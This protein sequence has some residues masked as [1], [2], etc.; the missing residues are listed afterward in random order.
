MTEA[1]QMTVEAEL[2][3]A[4]K[5][6]LAHNGRA[7][8]AIVRDL[9]ERHLRY[10]GSTLA[11]ELLDNWE[12]ARRKFVKVFPHEYKRALS[13]MHVRQGIAAAKSAGKVREAA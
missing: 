2:V 4:G 1:E 6:R 10:T 7:D 3:V 8:E 12:I 5:G 11:L 9:T 13:E